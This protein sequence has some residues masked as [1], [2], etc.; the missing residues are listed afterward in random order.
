MSSILVS[1]IIPVYNAEK[2]LEECLDS[3]LRQTLEE[4]EIIC[5]NDES[6]D[7][8]ADIL[9]R[10]KAE[11]AN[12]IV[13][14]Q[15]NQG[16]GIA[17]NFG[18]KHAS[19]EFIAFM[20]SDDY[21]P[22][23]DVLKKLYNT[24]IEKK[25][26]ICGGSMVSLGNESD[27]SHTFEENK[28]MYYREFQGTFSFVQFLYLTSFLRKNKIT[29]PLY[30]RY[31]DSPFFV[32]AMVKADQFYVISDRV[33]VYRNTD[34]F[35][36]YS[37]ANISLDVLN[38]ILDI[39][40]ISKRNQ[41]E[42]L[43]TN[44]VIT[45]MEESIPYVY[46]LIYNKNKDVRKCYEKAL[47]EIDEILLERDGR[48]IKKPKLLSDNE[49][50]Q[51]VDQSLRKEKELLERINSYE[52]V[53]IYGAG[54]VGR[55]FYHYLLQRGCSVN[56]TFMVSAENPNCTAC[57]KQVKSIKECVGKRNDALVIIAN[58]YD[59]K[60]MKET[61]QKYQFKNIEIVSYEEIQLF[62]A[63]I[64]EENALKIF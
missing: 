51:I 53:L 13:L 21:Y 52:N 16:S 9:E 33:Y 32:T 45:L 26:R 12:I 2:H 43:H 7:G 35:V 17:R 50:S 61:A 25:V 34:K 28:L 23:K 5:V 46:K 3:C 15:K 14:N 56:I 37:N 54:W 24:A 27:K 42:K 57:G 20:D 22:N 59:S 31:Q 1:I 40:I 55:R 29:F 63:D 4:V 10:Y 8:S 41:L 64:M 38:S 36:S 49:I 58:R 44:R 18:M 19:G 47:S 30:R 39:L 6:T 48:N 11:Y 62:G 60:E